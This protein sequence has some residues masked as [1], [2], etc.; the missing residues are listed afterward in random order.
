MV[1]LEI[2]QRPFITMPA[3]YTMLNTLPILIYLNMYWKYNCSRE[4]TTLEKF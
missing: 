3:N 1:Q 4:A 2:H